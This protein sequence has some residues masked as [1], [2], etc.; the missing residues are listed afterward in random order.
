MQLE[1]T[2]DK[3]IEVVGSQKALAEM[4]GVAPQ[5]LSNFKNGTRYCGYKKQA[6]IAAIAGEDPTR[7]ILEAMAADLDEND[8]IQKGAKEMIQA[9]LDAFPN[10]S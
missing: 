6:Q 5:H 2:I 4:I 10:H 8:E 7:V 9:M 1:K 3:A